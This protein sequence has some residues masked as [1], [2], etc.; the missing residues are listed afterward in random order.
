MSSVSLSLCL[1]LC[2][3]AAH[4]VSGSALHV[5]S[6][7]DQGGGCMNINEALREVASNTVLWLS[8]GRHVVDTFV[9]HEDFDNISFRGDGTGDVVVTC[10]EGIGLAFMNVSNLLF[11]NMTIDGCGLSGVSNWSTVLRATR[12]IIDEAIKIPL[13]G[14]VTVKVALFMAHCENVTMDHVNVVNTIGIGLLAVNTIGNTLLESVSF[15]RNIPPEC[16]L[17]LTIVDLEISDFRRWI[18]GGAYF[19]YEDYTNESEYAPPATQLHIVGSSFLNN[20]DCGVVGGTEQFIEYSAA[21]REPGYYIGA[22]GGLSV[23]MTQAGFP[24]E[25]L[26]QSSEFHNNFAKFGGAAHIGVF[27]ELTNIHI[28]FLNCSFDQNG[29]HS[30]FSGGALTAFFNLWR[31]SDE[32]SSPSV[33]QRNITL[34]VIDSNFTNNEAYTGGA[35]FLGSLH[36]NQASRHD[37]SVTVLFER[38]KFDSNS[39]EGGM[40]LLAFERKE[41]GT[42]KGM[43]LELRDVVVSNNSYVSLLNIPYNQISGAI[44]IRAVN[45]TVSG[46]SCLQGNFGSALVGV[47][48]VVN[49][50]GNI[51]FSTN[52]AFNGGALRLLDLSFLVV[53]SNTSVLFENNS[54]AVSGGAIYVELFVNEFRY[55]YDDCFL[56]FEE[57]SALYCTDTSCPQVLELNISITFQGNKAQSGSAI[58]GSTLEVC[59]WRISVSGSGNNNSSLLQT[60]NEHTTLMNFNPPPVGAIQVSTPSDSIQVNEGSLEVMPGQEFKLT[61]HA[62]DKLGQSVVEEITSV[63]ASRGLP[64]TTASQLGASGF[65]LLNPGDP[66]APITITGERNQSVTVQLFSTGSPA[67]GSFTAHLTS[68]LAGFVYNSDNR[69]C[70]C[71]RRLLDKDVVCNVIAQEHQVHDHVWYG[72]INDNVVEYTEVINDKLVVY[73]C[74]LGYCRDGDK[75]VPVGEYS[76]QC[77]EDYHRD[78]FLCGKCQDGYSVQLG[79]YRCQKCT[80]Y[81][82][83]ILALPLIAGVVLVV[84]MGSLHV[85]VTEGYL[86]PLLFYSNTVHTF[87]VEFCPNL[88]GSGVFVLMTLFSFDLG[89][90][91]CLYNGMDTLV[92]NVVCLLL[93]GYILALVLIISLIARWVKLPSFMDSYSPAKVLTTLLFVSYVAILQICIGI[94]SGIGVETLDGDT[95]I[96]WYLDPTVRYFTKAHGF[97]C[98]VSIVLI[99]FYIIPLPI[100]GLVPSRVYR[101]KYTRS[102]KPLYDA[103]WAPFKMQY[104]FWLGIRL[105]LRWVIFGFAYFILPPHNLLALGVLLV[106]LLSIQTKIQ[107]FRGFWRNLIDDCLVANLIVLTLGTIYFRA[108]DDN[109]STNQ[110]I[111][112]TVVAFMGYVVFLGVFVR[113]AFLRFPKLKEYALQLPTRLM[114]LFSRTPKKQVDDTASCDVKE[115]QTPNSPTN[116]TDQNVQIEMSNVWQSEHL[117]P[118]DVGSSPTIPNAP[119]VVSFTELREPLLEEGEVEVLTKSI[120]IGSLS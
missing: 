51:V 9:F 41:S 33:G 44:T 22:S 93:I 42:D 117:E 2:L 48:A 110:L 8:D 99:V 114:R 100:V 37:N 59:P 88:P 18:G 92:F 32:Y 80:N 105:I 84:L 96:R 52:T 72:P 97:L 14:N 107:P 98:I 12:A 57:I 69:S 90:E 62:L 43:Q 30:T 5:C 20:Q 81:S 19:L 49:L 39:A 103:M 47:R 38:C 111:F 94:L 6:G 104:R 11:Q 16:N 24:V 86:Y 15:E 64:G 87:V 34:E 23:M 120:T 115:P 27:E 53:H 61:A 85:G 68:C 3:V 65:W 67:T 1:L 79:S 35:V 40:A 4:G 58:Y 75:V 29:N 118:R 78:G 26:I 25:V 70:V 50:N 21:L 101:W 73:S 76:S 17:S 74:V 56:Y 55:Y 102:F 60:L 46:I 10:S 108:V 45:L 109:G 83:F 95:E 7:G 36:D 116:Q 119:R 54:A 31:N 63:I 77:A 13:E 113:H 82:L 66:Q 28:R 106:V 71:D 89:F 91:A 112:T